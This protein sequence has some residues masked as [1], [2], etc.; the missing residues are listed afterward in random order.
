MLIIDEF[1]SAFHNQLEELLISYF[2]ETSTNAQIFIVSHSTNLLSNNIF[3]PDQ[4]YA[5]EF[6]GNDGSCINRFSNEKPREAQNIEKMY[7]NGI[8]GE[9]PVYVNE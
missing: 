4:E 9:M 6:H 1:S 3:R 2:M 7:V 5:V 8:F